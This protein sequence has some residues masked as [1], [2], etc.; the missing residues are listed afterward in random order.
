LFGF[1][2]MSIAALTGAWIGA[3]HDGTV[4]P[5]AFTMSAFA[6]VVFATAFGWI[7]R[8]H[9]PTRASI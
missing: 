4:Y 1:L 8:L 3:S 9:T 7:A 5:L 2:A 6:L